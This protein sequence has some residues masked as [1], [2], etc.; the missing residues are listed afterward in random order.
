MKKLCTKKCKKC[1]GK[2]CPNYY[3]YMT[4][5]DKVEYYSGVLHSRKP[6]FVSDINEQ[7]RK[8]EKM[9]DYKDWGLVYG[10]ILLFTLL[11]IFGG[12]LI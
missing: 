11:I 5:T 7:N 12:L 9:M 3:G 1:K 2:C 6:M 10:L 4:K 8:I